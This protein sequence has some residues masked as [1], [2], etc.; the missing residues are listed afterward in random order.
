MCHPLDSSSWWQDWKKIEHLM[1]TNNRGTND[2]VKTMTGPQL[3]VWDDPRFW[4]EFDQLAP[5]FEIVEFAGGE[6]LLDPL[7]HE[8]LTRL[9][10]Y[11]EKIKLKY[12]TNLTNIRFGKTRFF[13]V[14]KNF[15]TVQLNVSID[16]LGDVYDYI[17][18][19]ASWEQTLNN[20]KAVKQLPNV[21]L[22]IQNTVQ[23]YNIH[24]LPAFIDFF[25]DE[26]GS[27]V[28]THR[29]DFPRCLSIK[30][31][32]LGYRAKMI[33]M[34]QTYANG[35]KHGGRDSWS[36]QRRL[37]IY[38]LIQDEIKILQNHN[39]SQFLSDFVQ[40]SDILDK[41]QNVRLTWRELLPDLSNELKEYT[42]ASV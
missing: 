19:D 28:T 13:E 20:I 5:F 8:I 32:P 42:C 7:H 30:S 37:I 33:D 40:F 27:I 38:D 1:S 9:V 12:A 34:L 24:Q 31:L 16:G 3:G 15:H 41:E 6:P 25:V 11:G 23:I 17:R 10:P 35:I 39:T 26:I 2:R 36:E 22:M 14:W 29:V 4:D 18:Q 21:V